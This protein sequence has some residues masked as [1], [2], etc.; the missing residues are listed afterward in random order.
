[1]AR[2]SNTKPIQYGPKET[3]SWSFSKL[4]EYMSCPRKHNNTRL[5][6][7]P[8]EPSDAQNY[9]DAMH[10]AFQRRVTQGLKMPTGFIAF[11][12]WG[13]D[14]AKLMHPLEITA[15]EKEIALTRD[16]KPT[17]Y[18]DNNVWMRMKIDL[19]KLVPN[20]TGKF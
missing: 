5:K 19:V 15:C 1:M 14:A 6:K 4:T 13:N 17:G 3:F 18:F 16:L 8:E 20:K 2:F 9:G 7:F 10:R 11:E 12:E